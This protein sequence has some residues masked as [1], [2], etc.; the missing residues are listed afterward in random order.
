M[1]SLFKRD[2]YQK[3]SQFTPVLFRLHFHGPKSWKI[4]GAPIASLGDVRDKGRD[5]RKKRRITAVVLIKIGLGPC[6]AFL[7]PILIM[8]VTTWTSRHFWG[9]Y[10]CTLYCPNWELS[11][12]P[13][14]AS[15]DV[16]AL[17]SVNWSPDIKQNNL[18]QFSCDFQWFA[19]QSINYLNTVVLFGRGADRDWL[20][21]KQ[22]VGGTCARLV[23]LPAERFLD[24]GWQHWTYDNSE[25]NC[26]PIQGL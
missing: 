12:S 25:E 20:P 16:I 6:S 19:A 24:Q 14:K 21:R 18:R 13:K 15:C 8:C 23:L 9:E 17:P 10:F 2:M 1:A 3:S 4:D 22:G 11:L 26:L 7:R 5:I